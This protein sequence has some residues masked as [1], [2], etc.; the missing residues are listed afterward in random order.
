LAKEKID[1]NGHS[2]TVTISVGVASFPEHGDDA[3][4]IISKADAALYQAKKRGRDRVVLAT[5]GQKKKRKK[6]AQ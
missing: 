6:A 1:A 3:Q 5:R 4:G 2:V